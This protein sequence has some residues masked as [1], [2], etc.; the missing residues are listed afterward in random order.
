MRGFLQRFDLRLR[1]PPFH[2]LRGALQECIRFRAADEESRHFEFWELT[3][4]IKVMQACMVDAGL[5]F[6]GIDQF[7]MIVDFARDSFNVNTQIFIT[8]ITKY[9]AASV[10]AENEVQVVK[11]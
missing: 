5:P 11:G 4:D 2:E 6:W 3:P 9:L 7:I 1:L 10:A 8:H